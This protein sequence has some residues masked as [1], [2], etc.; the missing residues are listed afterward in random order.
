MYIKFRTTGKFLL[1]DLFDER[2]PRLDLFYAVRSESTVSLDTVYCLVREKEN[3]DVHA[4][5]NL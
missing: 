4:H 3:V 1:N 5:R 2:G